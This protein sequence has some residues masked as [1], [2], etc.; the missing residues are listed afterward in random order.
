MQ[1]NKIVDTGERIGIGTSPPPYKLEWNEN[2]RIGFGP[3]HTG[4]LHVSGEYTIIGPHG[5]NCGCRW[6]DKEGNKL[7]YAGMGCTNPS[8]KLEID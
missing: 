4:S 2:T 5:E 7:E 1:K 3:I 6:Y 8:R